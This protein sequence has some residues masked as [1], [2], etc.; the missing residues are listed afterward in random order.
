MAALLLFGCGG[1]NR[2]DTAPA[3]GAGAETGAVPGGTGQ[4]DTSTMMPPDSSAM[5]VDS[6]GDTSAG[7]DT[8]A[9][10]DSAKGNQS[11]SGVTNTESGKSTLGPG[12][13]QTRPDQDQPVTSKGDTIGTT[14]PGSTSRGDTGS[15]SQ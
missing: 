3:A 4:V 12:V 10:T 9:G 5:P 6:A 14:Q 13:N 7:R 15:S 8:T 1:P 2:N 11:K